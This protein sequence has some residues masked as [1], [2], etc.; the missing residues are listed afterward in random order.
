MGPRE[1]I[2]KCIS[3]P[4]TSLRI[5]WNR[6]RAFAPLC[7]SDNLRQ[8]SLAQPGDFAALPSI[9]IGKTPMDGRPG[10]AAGAFFRRIKGN[11]FRL[12]T[13]QFPELGSPSLMNG[14]HA[15]RIRA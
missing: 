11:Y 9:A 10:S 4:G 6:W 2:P 14:V 15:S 1:R 5:A 7:V 12:L 8:T 3:E 13:P